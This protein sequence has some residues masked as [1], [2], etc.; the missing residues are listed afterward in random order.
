MLCFTVSRDIEMLKRHYSL[1]RLSIRECHIVCLKKNI[2][3]LYLIRL[4]LGIWDGTMLLF[5]A[6]MRWE[7]SSKVPKMV[8][9]DSKISVR[10]WKVCSVGYRTLGNV[11][12]TWSRN[13]IIDKFYR[14]LYLLDENHF[15][16]FI[17]FISAHLFLSKRM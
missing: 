2:Y 12:D 6:F 13:A 16:G 17:F 15:E 3:N 4:M 7:K 5:R 11:S 8:W 1:M 9:F 14:I 10:K